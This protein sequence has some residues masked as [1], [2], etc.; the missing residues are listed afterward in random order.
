V[1]VAKKRR[2][3]VQPHGQIRQSQIVTTFGPGAMIDLPDHAV[4]LAGL[5]HWSGYEDHPIVED[6]LA[7]K[8]RNLLGRPFA[9]YAP[10][11]D[12]DDPTGPVT[13]IT[14]WLF[15]EWFVG[16]D[17][18]RDST[19]TRSRPLVHR[20][21]LDKGMKLR[22]EA[23]DKPQR[24]VPVRFVQACTRGHV[25]DIDWRVFVH[26]KGVTC[27]RR[28][29]LDERGTTGDLTD[30]AV[31]CECGQFKALSAATRMQDLPLG[32][33]NG[34]RPWLGAN[35]RERCGDGAARAV[36]PNRLLVRAASN[37]YF[38]QT[39][40][41]IS[42]PEPG[43]KLRTAV[44]EVWAQFLQAVTSADQ[45][46]FVRT[47][48][49][50]K[51]AL[52]GFSDA[53]VWAEI[54]RRRA[55]VVAAA[56]GIREAELETLLQSPGEVGDDQPDGWFFARTSPIPPG[57]PALTRSISR[58]V[59]VHRLREV[60][61]QV[62]FTRFES[63]VPDVNGELDLNVERAALSLNQQWLPA[64]ENRG[65]GV[66]IGFKASDIEAWM[67]RP[68]VEARGERLLAGYKAWLKD[69]QGVTAQF[70]GL[71]FVM[72]HTLSHLLITAVALDC[73]YAASSIRERI[74]VGDAGYGI[75][76]YTASP[77]SE[78]T[79]GGLVEA[80]DRIDL[81]LRQAIDMGRL[82]ANDPVCAQHQPDNRQEDR[83]LSGAACHGCVLLAES[84]CERRND[85][86]DRALVVST[87]DS[88][89][90]AFFDV[91][92]A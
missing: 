71:P 33:C 70:P 6:R 7:A 62:G 90:T 17:A 74:Y 15:P 13:G 8:V 16:Q 87:V 81:H 47:M 44:E 68:A 76:L 36:Q 9:F 3:E 21:D 1:S 20:L 39:L 41:A 85:F 31:R 79:L 14:V 57:E 32:Y 10:P 84:S 45:L 72:L 27:T 12:N 83:L 11:A 42:I 34:P 59:K 89:G 91:D 55:G 61:V 22:L 24:V 69:H 37:A 49:G 25:S 29:W 58:L 54:Q 63:S 35:A 82:C 51:L 23:R 43:M 18:R 46:T 19:G 67:V 75:L 77:D 78:G 65:E 60:I 38:A 66:F 5:D 53:D 80:A 52:E 88:E 56:K 28:L 86:L 26:G 4:I 40:S 30:I 73:G 48:P 50:V 64:V 92:N 2:G